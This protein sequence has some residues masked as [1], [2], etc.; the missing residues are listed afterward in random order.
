MN[1]LQQEIDSLRNN[2]AAKDAAL[3][4]AN[5]AAAQV[6]ATKNNVAAAPA[7]SSSGSSDSGLVIAIIAIVVGFLALASMGLYFA[8]RRRPGEV[9][10][11]AAGSRRA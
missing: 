6:A 9:D 5:I 7:S 4:K 11:E 8:L 3:D 1:K 2:L 10:L